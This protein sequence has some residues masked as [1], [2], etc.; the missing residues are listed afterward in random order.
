MSGG[1]YDYLYAKVDDMASRLCGSKD[2]MRR[3]FAK[4]LELVSK[5]MYAVEWVDSGD[6]I[7]G[8]EHKSI[9]EVL[10]ANLVPMVL[11]ECIDDAL[12]AKR[13]L[14]MVLERAQK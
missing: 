7:S 4:H 10:G 8:D 3:A 9:N 5:A 6:C 14:E 1:S 2:P 11:Q 13:N 12:L